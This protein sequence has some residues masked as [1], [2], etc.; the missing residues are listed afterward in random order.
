MDNLSDVIVF[1]KTEQ[2]ALIRSIWLIQNANFPSSVSKFF[3]SN[4]F[5]TLGSLFIVRFYKKIDAFMVSVVVIDEDIARDLEDL[6]KVREAL[7]QERELA[8]AQSSGVEA[9]K[10]HKL[11]LQNQ[12]A[13][14][15]SISN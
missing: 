12:L 2:I 6:K 4:F 9:E 7:N 14:V 15:L 13:F 3:C 5:K 10:Q 11:L 8:E 1:M